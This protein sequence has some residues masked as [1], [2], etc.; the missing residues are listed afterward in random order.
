MIYFACICFVIGAYMER[1]VEKGKSR[2]FDNLRWFVVSVI[3]V[4]QI[5]GIA[6]NGS[7]PINLIWLLAGSI[8]IVNLIFCRPFVCQLPVFF[9][10][11]LLCPYFWDEMFWSTAVHP[12]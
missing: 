11:S 12:R 1:S 7:L 8:L 5:S 3:L 2:W 4:L 10:W 9:G 6:P